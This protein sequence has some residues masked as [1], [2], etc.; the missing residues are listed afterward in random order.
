MDQQG[1]R[2]D[3]ADILLFCHLQPGARKTEF[4][5][6]HDGRIKIRINAPPVDGKANLLL[7]QFLSKL[8]GVARRQV[9]IESGELSR[10][11]R[12]RVIEP[13]QIPIELQQL[14]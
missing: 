3:A 8:F 13:A 2:Q 9:V 6:L 1:W 7:I 11:K 4:A 5:G 14:K 12:V 10:K